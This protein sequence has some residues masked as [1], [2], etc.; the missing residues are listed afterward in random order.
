MPKP[1]AK[2]EIDFINHPKFRCLNANAICLWLEGK[3]YC[4]KHMTDGLIPAHEVKRFR[5]GGK[6]SIACLLTS[7]GPKNEGEQYQPLWVAHA[8]GYKM[9]DYLD[10]N[11]CREAVL[12]RMEQVDRAR[13]LDREYKAKGRAAKKVKR[14]ACDVRSDVR[15]DKPDASGACPV[16][17]RLYTV[18]ASETHKKV[19]KEQKPLAPHPIKAFLTLYEELFFGLTGERPVFSNGRDAKIAKRT[20]DQLGE[21]KAHAILRAFFASQDK[22]IQDAGFGLNVFAGQINKLLADQRPRA[23]A[24]FVGGRTGAPHVGKYDGLEERD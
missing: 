17:V 14:E 9:H 10:Y 12:A 20:I 15:S 13:E 16:D 2:T 19:S 5:F 21:D 23:V 4:D 8:V 3:N 18:P 11:D 1:W 7:A 24:Q 22:F 6:K